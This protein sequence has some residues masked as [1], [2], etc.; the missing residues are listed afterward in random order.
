[1]KIR[2]GIIGLGGVGSKWDQ[3]MVCYP[4][5]THVGA[6]LQADNLELKAVC[7]SSDVNRA[8]FVEDWNLNL[9]VYAS[10]SEMLSTESFDVVGVVVP[11]DCHFSVL[12]EV[13]KSRPKVVLCEKPFCKTVS[14]AEKI[15]NLSKEMSAVL[16]VNYH[17][18]WDE[19][20]RK[21]KAWTDTKGIPRHVSV[22]YKKGL[23]NYGS[24]LAN[25]LLFLFGPVESVLSDVL[26]EGQKN[27]NDPSISS[28]LNF[29]SGLQVVVKG[30]DDVDYELCDI[31]IFYPDTKLHIEMGGYIIDMYKAVNNLYFEDYVNL[32]RCDDV[33]CKGP[34]NGLT[35]AYKEIEDF[36]LHGVPCKV[37]TAEVAIETLKVLG[38]M[39]ASAE[40]NKLIHL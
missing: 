22:L 29:R 15:F 20:I 25:L 40:S 10:V 16:S 11:T 34:L 14:E 30:L 39:K 26:P 37:N 27:A 7:D 1:V 18:R 23:L 38:A 9:P 17:R 2:A 36:I 6:I 33:F 21:I 28:M 4:P 12:S 24:H 35:G 19:K 3:G 32:D 5:R 31:D 13:L 8:K